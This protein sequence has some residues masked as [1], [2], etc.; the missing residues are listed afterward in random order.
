MAIG[1]ES[2]AQIVRGQE[3]QFPGT[4]TARNV[5]ALAIIVWI[6]NGVGYVGIVMT[7][8]AIGML[9]VFK[10]AI[11][12]TGVRPVLGGLLGKDII[13]FRMTGRAER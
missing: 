13:L 8:K 5:T 6:L 10:M 3:G 7:V 2:I 12:T 4:V 1:T 9:L 11:G